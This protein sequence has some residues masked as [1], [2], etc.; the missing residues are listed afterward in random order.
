[1]TPVM[2][3]GDPDPRCPG[4]TRAVFKFRQPDDLFH[5]LKTVKGLLLLVPPRTPRISGYDVYAH[6]YAHAFYVVLCYMSITCICLLYVL[7][8]Y[9]SLKCY[10]SGM[11]LVLAV[12]SYLYM[13][14]ICCICYMSLI[15]YMS[16]ICLVQGGSQGQVIYYL[17]AFV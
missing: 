11:C 5:T 9:M 2:A 3:D 12:S 7:I 4:Q 14:V 13:S 16:V 15:C 10:V 8:C 6:A 1:M 17:C